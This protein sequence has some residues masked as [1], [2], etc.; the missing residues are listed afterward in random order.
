MVL[1]LCNKLKTDE[2]TSH[3]PVVPLTARQSDQSQMEGCET[4]ADAYITK[5]FSSALPLVRIKNL[6]ESRRRPGII[7]YRRRFRYRFN[8][9]QSR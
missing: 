1:E 8:C 4:G 2:K 6:L 7:Q 3:I 5:P 9:Y